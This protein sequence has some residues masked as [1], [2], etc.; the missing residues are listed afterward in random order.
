MY[1]A[2]DERSLL[3]LLAGQYPTHAPTIDM[4]TLITSFSSRARTSDLGQIPALSP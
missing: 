4:W 2:E 3:N 1:E